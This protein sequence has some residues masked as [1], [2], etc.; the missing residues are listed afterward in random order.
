[1][2]I[3]SFDRCKSEVLAKKLC[4]MHYMR[5]RRSGSPEPKIDQAKGSSECLVDG[6]DRPSICRGWCGL[7]YQ[8]WRRTNDPVGTV[9]PTKGDRCCAAACDKAQ[10][11]KGYCQ[12]HYY[13]FWKHGSA[14]AGRD[15]PKRK[16]GEGTRN[17]GYHFTT[18]Y[19]NGVQRQIGTHRL[20]MQ[21]HLGRELRKG[22][23]V[24]HINGDR[25]DNRIENLELWVK[26]QPSGQRPQDLVQWAREILALYEHEVR[27]G[28]A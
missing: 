7:H 15:S 6:C 8:R 11:A 2:S 24:H 25:D 9:T 12:N 22:E 18:I 3:C 21:K 19:Q 16:P 28:L 1:M 13:R 23:N 26:T 5:M 27:G 17:N 20:V 10:Y 4:A 14:T